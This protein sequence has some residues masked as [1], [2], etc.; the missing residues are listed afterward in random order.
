MPELS[1]DQIT[2][3][4]DRIGVRDALQDTLKDASRGA[5]SRA[6]SKD[7]LKAALKDALKPDV[8][9][10]RL[11]HR[12]HVLTVPFENLSV[13]LPG[14]ETSLELPALVDKIVTRRRGGFCY[15]LNGLFAALLEAIGFGVERMA[16]RTY[17]AERGAFTNSPLDHLALRVT[18]A[19]GEVW[20]A[21][22]GFGKHSELPLRYTERGAQPDPFGTF[23]LVE[24]AD[25]LLDV[26]LNGSPQYRIDPRALELADFEMGR[27]WQVTSP[28]SV[29]R[30]NLMCSL[31]TPDGRVTLNGR[32]LITTDADGRREKVLK[33]DAAVLAA[34]RELFGIELAAVPTIA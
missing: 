6:A 24:T 22:V 9:T 16:A 15:E 5:A 34:Y 21:D 23:Q 12:A 17:S 32:R 2:A 19:A 28:A 8:D 29:F 1:A 26:Q 20:L 14:E 11:L 25:G 4:L 10:L 13:H 33:E 18:D 30:R 27:W 7:A 3:Y 31:P